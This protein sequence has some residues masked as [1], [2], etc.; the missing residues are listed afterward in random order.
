MEEYKI[1]I[2]K[3]FENAEMKYE[4]ELRLTN[5]N[6]HTPFELARTTWWNGIYIAILQK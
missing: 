5:D 3:A 6:S 4:K 2:E 1:H